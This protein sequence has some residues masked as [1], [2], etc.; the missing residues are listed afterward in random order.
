MA[1][2]FL[3]PGRPQSHDDWW[4]RRD[5]GFVTSNR[6]RTSELSTPPM[7]TM[8]RLE[9]APEPGSSASASGM[10]PSMTEKLVITI[11]RNRVNALSRSRRACLAARAQRVGVVDEQDAV[12]GRDADQQ[13]R[14][15]QREEVERLVRE[16]ER[17]ERADRRDRHGEQDDERRAVAVVERDH[18]QK[19]EDDRKDQRASEA[20][21]AS[22]S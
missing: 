22:G 12:L 16:H 5:V 9:R 20:A 13:H 11:G 8:P 3:P 21:A 4:I 17:A 6:V 18:Q 7:T 19:H 15:D 1:D 14:A 2:T 10:L